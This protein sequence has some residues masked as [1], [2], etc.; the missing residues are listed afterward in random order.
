MNNSRNLVVA[1]VGALV[2]A[3]TLAAG[4]TPASAA[5]SPPRSRP[6]IHSRPGR[7][8]ST[9]ASPPASPARRRPASRATSPTRSSQVTANGENAGA[10]RSRRTSSTATQTPSGSSSSRTGWVELELAEPVKVVALRARPRPTTRPAAT[11][12]TGRSRAP[13]T[14]QTG[15]RS[16]RRRARR[17][18]RA[19]RPR[20]TRS[21]TTRPTSYYRL[22]I[23]AQPRRGHRPARRAAALERR[24]PRRRRRPSCAAPSAAARAAAT[25][26]RPASA[27]PACARCSTAASTPPTAAATPTTRSS[28]STWRSRRRREL[29]YVIFPDF[30]RDDLQLP[31]HVRGRRPR[32]HRR[33]LPE[34][35][36]R[37]RPARRDAQPAA[38]RARRRRSTR[39]SGTPSVSRIGDVAAGKTIDRILVAYDNPDGPADFGGWVDDIDDRRASPV[40]RSA[41][42]LSDWVVTTR[43]TNSS[44]SFSRGNNIPATAVPHGFNFWTPVTNAGTT[45]WLYEYQRA[46]NADEP[47]DAPGVRGQPRA[48]PVDGRPAD[49]PGDAVGGDGHAGRR[50]AAPARCR[51][52]TR[53]R[54][55]SRTTTASRSR[56]GI[57]TEIAPTDHAAIFRFTFTGASSNLI[58]DNV[59]NDGGRSRSTRRTAS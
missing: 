1:T 46:N 6:P 57:K 11:R 28:T 9:R 18:A 25:T 17:S 42:H 20:T 35:P 38:A 7:T 37:D 49:L 56:T 16:T 40:H 14:A 48:E 58:F 19:S 45:S 44:G 29:S 27:S 32:L 30:E 4:G 52:G 3:A 36:R 50:A 5:A 21:P 54:S 8:P 22:D 12:A 55:R 24:G 53:T 43:G 23:T 13:T 41:S 51:S 33:H 39:T 2:V 47:A 10:A 59:N 26:P 34:R 31:E 15:R